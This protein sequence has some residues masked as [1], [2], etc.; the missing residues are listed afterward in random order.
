ACTVE[1]VRDG[2]FREHSAAA[3]LLSGQEAVKEL[4]ALADRWCIGECSE[5]DAPGA[6]RGQ[7]YDP[8]GLACAQQA[9]AMRIDARHFPHGVDS[10]DGVRRQPVEVAIVARA[11]DTL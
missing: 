5:G 4:F 10:P 9:D 3:S 7:G 6:R 1:S 2:L 11:T 8:A